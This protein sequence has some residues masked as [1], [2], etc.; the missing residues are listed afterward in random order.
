MNNSFKGLTVRPEFREQGAVIIRCGS[1]NGALCLTNPCNHV[2]VLAD[3][4]HPV[5][6]RF[7]MFGD[8][9]A[10][11]EFIHEEQPT[12]RFLIFSSKIWFGLF[13][14]G[15]VEPLADILLLLQRLL[16]GLRALATA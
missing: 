16:Y 11:P 6:T 15:H 7:E 9:G 4:K 14:N 12:E 2:T 10:N 1:I 3:C 5:S 13:P 8:A